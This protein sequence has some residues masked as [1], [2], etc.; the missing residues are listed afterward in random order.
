MS[1]TPGQKAV[2]IVA[3]LAV[4]VGGFL[5]STWAGKPTY[6]PLFTNLSASDASAIV[7]KLNSAKKPYKLGEAGTEILV[8]QSDVYNER[9]TMSA[10]G[11][12]TAGQSNFSLLDKEGITTSDFVQHVDYQ[13]ALEGELQNTMTAISGV[14]AAQ[15][16]LALPDQAS[17]FNDNTQKTTAA[18][19]LTLAPGT[20]LTSEQIRSIVN[21]T[22]SSVAGLT[23]DNVTVSDST[24]KVLSAAGSAT[25]GVDA[26]TQAEQTQSFDN[27]LTS[28]VQA[29]LD[30]VLGP[31]HS[32]VTVNA[33]LDFNSD[34]KTA[35]TYTYSPGI[36]PVAISSSDESYSGNG[37]STAGVLGA[38]S[39]SPTAPVPS[40][41]STGGSYDKKS[42][43]QN[44]AVG[45][46]NEV[47][48]AAPGSVKQLGVAV[49]LDK[50]TVGGAADEATVQ[51][52]VSSAMNLNTK[53]GDTIQVKTIPFDTSAAK[54][55]AAAAAAAKAA[56]AKSASQAHL[57]EL[58]KTGLVVVA[59]IAALIVML[60][61]G[62]RRKN[63]AVPAEPG[64]DDLDNFLATL[65]EEEPADIRRE[66][67]MRVNPNAVDSA[68]LN[69]QREAVSELADQQPEDVARMLRSWLNTKGS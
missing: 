18:V 61:F 2:T 51:S 32:S 67:A 6:A 31:G 33:L 60:I 37:A 57:M 65:H 29:M 44:N 48:V 15:V 7:D 39:P 14:Q 16:H 28:K 11:L 69:A 26:S 34:T 38:V 40:G 9:L 66:P 63:A 62:R 64:P 21:L 17:V 36:P 56:A 12:P 42:L 27:Q 8:P 13:Q 22:A 49:V 45:T 25:S 68:E 55:Q 24:G 30:Q 54:A 47:T 10:A 41:S 53:R 35:N 58:I 59:I 52:L 1:F 46:V 3:A 20:T 19:L 50:N 43:V 5:F 4:V 23:P